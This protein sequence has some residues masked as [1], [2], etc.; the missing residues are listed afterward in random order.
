MDALNNSATEQRQQV[1]ILQ[2][3]QKVTK[4]QVHMCDR[5][6]SHLEGENERDCIEAEKIH[7]R[8]MERKRMDIEVLRKEAKLMTLKVQLAQLNTGG[9]TSGT[10]PGASS[11]GFSATAVLGPS[12]SHSSTVTTT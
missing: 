11:I 10:T 1:A 9:P 8:M 3:E 12:T 7:E 6:I 2:N 5:K 4:L